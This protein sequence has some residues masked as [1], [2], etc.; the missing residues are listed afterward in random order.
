MRRAGVDFSSTET[1]NIRD[2]VAFAADRC[3][4]QSSLARQCD[5]RQP[6]IAAIISGARGAGI[7]SLMAVATAM[8]VTVDDIVSGAATM[9]LRALSGTVVDVENHS[10]RS[11]AAR[12]LATLY[13]LPLPDV[14]WL[15]D[16]L[17]ISVPDLVPAT[18]WFDSARSLLERRR[19]S[20]QLPSSHSSRA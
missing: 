4:S 11:R 19:L 10:E 17:G 1:R 7:K 9:R 2:F 8:G 13:N 12:A 6:T 3:G 16:D 14:F 20:G 15:F 18:V 5:V